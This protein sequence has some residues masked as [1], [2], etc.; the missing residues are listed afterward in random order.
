MLA[1]ALLVKLFYGT[2]AKRTDSPIKL[3]CIKQALSHLLRTVVIHQDLTGEE[4][5]NHLLVLA[6]SG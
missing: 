2:K 1:L 3:S 4:K 6:W 5:A